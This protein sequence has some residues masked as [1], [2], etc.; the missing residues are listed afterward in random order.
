MNKKQKRIK[1]SVSLPAPMV[2]WLK[3]MAERNFDDV[4]GVIRQALLPV[5]RKDLEGS[6]EGEGD[7]PGRIIVPTSRR[8]RGVGTSGSQLK[9][10][11]AELLEKCVV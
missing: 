2:D 9:N 4:S 11:D 7:V 5:M 10:D 8:H 6:K 3:N 1:L